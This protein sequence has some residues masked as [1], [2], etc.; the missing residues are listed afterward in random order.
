MMAPGSHQWSASLIGA[1]SDLRSWAE[2]FCELFDPVVQLD[3]ER[4][5]LFSSSFQSVSDAS[6]LRA[7]ARPLIERL[8]GIMRLTRAAGPIQFGG[9]TQIDKNGNKHTTVFL[10]STLAI[11]AFTG[12]ATLTVLGPDG[13]PAP[14]PPPAQTEAQRWNALAQAD[15]LLSDALGHASRADDWFEIYKAIES[16]EARHGGEKP[17][18]ELGLIPQSDLKRLKR[19]ANAHRHAKRK[20]DAPGDPVELSEAK[21]MLH[22]LIRR[23]IG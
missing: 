9:A 10:E 5:L 16:L 18:L 6:E 13:A 8:N 23:A 14:P 11:G 21:L 20:F 19:T 17:L 15:S 1:S 2:A 22:T 3:G 12:A 4:G 7:A